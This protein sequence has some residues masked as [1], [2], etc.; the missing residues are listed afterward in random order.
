[1]NAKE[2]AA[3]AALEH[4][5]SG[6]VIGLGTGSTAD[7]F[8]RALGAALKAGTL[9]DVK[10]VPT[11]IASDK[12]ARDLGI[13]IVSLAD[14]PDLDVAVDGTDE[15]DANLVMIKGLGGALLREKI[16]AQAAKRMIVIADESKVVQVLGVKTPLPVEVAAFSHDIHIPQFRTL[17]ADPT[18]RR[19][20]AGDIFTT[21]NGTHIYDCK[22][23]RVT[24]PR[25][26]EQ[27]IRRYAGVIDTGLFID[28]ATLAIIGTET[29]VRTL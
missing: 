19:T 4:V 23:P 6:T 24:D 2:R 17:G 10:G 18:L 14:Y 11:S 26:L 7:C 28:I 3:S 15:I 22:F 1:M 16:V 20:K 21:D 8:I 29:G 9:H 5:K 25:G 12:L 13:E 27:A